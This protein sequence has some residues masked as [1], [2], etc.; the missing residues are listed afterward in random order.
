MHLH[1]K[2]LA[3]LKWSIAFIAER[4]DEILNHTGELKNDIP[5]FPAP[6]REERLCG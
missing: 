4:L 3:D 2:S 5:S 1:G 6:A